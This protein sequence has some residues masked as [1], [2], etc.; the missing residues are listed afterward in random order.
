MYVNKLRD[1]LI[2]SCVER[3]EVGR[4]LF[5]RVGSLGLWLPFFSP[6]VIFPLFHECV[7]VV[8][9]CSGMAHGAYLVLQNVMH[10]GFK[11]FPPR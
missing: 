2:L 8:C 7:S 5:N 6:S 4:V 11:F 10:L 1:L 3:V 9:L